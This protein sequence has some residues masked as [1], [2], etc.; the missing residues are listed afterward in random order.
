[1]G[2]LFTCALF[3]VLSAD[4]LRVARGDIDSLSSRVGVIIAA[5]VLYLLVSL[6]RLLWRFGQG[7]SRL[8]DGSP[9]APLTGGLA[10]NDSWILGIFYVNRSDPSLIVESRF[11][12]YDLNYGNPVALAMLAGFGAAG[13]GLLVLTLLELGVLG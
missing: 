13:L 5:M 4:I 2:S 1:M 7:G 6:V 11:L 9:E 10:D 12:G 3:A 8:E